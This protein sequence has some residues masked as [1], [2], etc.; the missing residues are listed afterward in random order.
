MATEIKSKL[1]TGLLKGWLKLRHGRRIVH[2]NQVLQRAEKFLICL[3]SKYG[4]GT[5]WVGG[6]PARIKGKFPR[7]RLTVAAHRTFQGWV[8]KSVHV[9]EALFFDETDQNFFC[10]P[11]KEIV[12]KVSNKGYDVAIDLGERFNLMTAYLC[13]CSGAKLR[14][15]FR[16]ETHYPF[17]NLAFHPQGETLT[18][19]SSVHLIDFLAS[20]RG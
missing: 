13:W 18:T 12:K 6:A 5:F 7:C 16:V 8:D 11:H 19:E 20:L 14:V 2:V 17:F 10:L 1:V 3:P 15:G 4:Q 9:D